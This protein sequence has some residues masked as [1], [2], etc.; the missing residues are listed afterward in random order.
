MSSLGFAGIATGDIY[1]A[2]FVKAGTGGFSVTQCGANDPVFGISQ[3]GTNGPPI[4]GSTN[5]KAAT[6]GQTLR[7]HKPGERCFVQA[8]A[9]IT[10]GNRLKAD[11]DGKAT[12][13]AGGTTTERIGAVALQDASTGEFCEVEVQISSETAS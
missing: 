13:V 2:R 9:A 7:V 6:V 11:T 8:G 12:P 5:D 1:P 3:F 10:S 4:P